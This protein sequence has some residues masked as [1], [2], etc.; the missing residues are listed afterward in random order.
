MSSLIKKLQPSGRVVTSLSLV[1]LLASA[2]PVGVF[3]QE[4]IV[5]RQ[6]QPA[7][8]QPQQQPKPPETPP[9]SPSKPP[10]PDTREQRERL[11]EHGTTNPNLPTER[12]RRNVPAPGQ[13][14]VTNPAVTPTPGAPAQDTGQ[15]SIT[16]PIAASPEVPETRVGVDLSQKAPLSV[17]DAIALALQN[18][19]DIAQ[20]RE[21]VQIANFSLMSLRGVYDILSSSDVNYRSQTIPV[22]SQ[23]AGGGSAFSVTQ[24]TLT[25]NFITNQYVER[26]GGFWQAEFDNN[27][28]TTSSTAQLLT[29]QYNPT[30]TLSFTQPLM[31]NF[32]LDLNRRNIQIAKKSLDLSDSQFRQRVI[33][34]INSVQ[35][36]YWDLVFAI[37][38]EEIARNTVELTRTQLIN[39]Q[40]QVEAGT[41]APIDLR[42]TEA[43]LEQRKGDVITALQNITTAENVL[44]SLIIQKQDDKLWTAVITPTDEPQATAQ[45]FNLDEATRLALTNRPELEQMRLQTEQNRIDVKFYENQ[46]KPQVDLVGF[47]SNTGLAGTP[48]TRAITGGFG[49]FDQGIITNLNSALSALNL[50]LFNP[51]APVDTTV[52]ASVP[53]RFDGGYF[54]SLRNLFSQDFKTYQFGV[55]FSFPWRNRTAEGNLGRALASGRQLDARQRQVVQTVQVDVRNAL[56]AVEAAR[57]RYEAAHAGALAANAQYQGELEK[58]RAGLSTNFFVLQRQTDLATAQGNEVRSL[59]DYNKALADLQRVTGMTLVTNNVQVTALVPQNGKK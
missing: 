2:L 3:A 59:T 8:Q 17:Q 57:R 16:Q 25:A 53:D 54:Q 27:R 23:F 43:A 56:Q 30:L 49:T 11:E 20:F 33:E 29:T 21:G 19:L 34:I 26:T 6:Q 47:Y 9:S 50:P 44:K 4:G 46:T 12:E 52:G 18:N 45:N 28:T 22:A 15:S 39:N 40:R 41:A 37:K 42:S 36:A 14:P 55:R 38:N 13:A 24:R 5:A 31:R 58:F 1:A 48:S 10:Q 32:K 51:L 35:R 7:Q